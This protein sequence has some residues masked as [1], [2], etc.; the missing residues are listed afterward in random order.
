MYITN[1]QPLQSSWNLGL[2]SGIF[3]RPAVNYSF[4]PTGQAFQSGISGIS[5]LG[6]TNFAFNPAQQV[7]GIS[8]WGQYPQHPA[9]IQAQAFAQQ[10]QLWSQQGQIF[11]QPQSWNQAQAFAQQPQLW[12][13]QVGFTGYPSFS[14]G[15]SHPA[16]ISGFQQPIQSSGY[17]TIQSTTG[18][19]QPRV[20]IAET[21]NDIVVTCELPN[22]NSGDLQLSVTDD[23][24]D[25]SGSSSVGGTFTSI[26]RTIALPTTIKAE[27]VDASY[28][29][30]M[31]H[32]RMP[33]SD[34]SARRRIK[35]NTVG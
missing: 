26:H 32:V 5:G 9:L 34:I 25:I 31:L 10:P 24:L 4:T 15:F 19:V 20:E 11:A 18:M 12:N 23:S 22:I 1:V 27:Q 7:S 6:A 17:N 13:Q 28:S 21:N 35:V 16:S 30:G 14:W 29:N 8:P 3:N 2:Q 33:K